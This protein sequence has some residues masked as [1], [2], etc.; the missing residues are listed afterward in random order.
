MGWPTAHYTTAYYTGRQ[1]ETSARIRT[2]LHLFGP[3]TI[4]PYTTGLHLI[5]TV[6]TK[7][8]YKM[9]HQPIGLYK[10]VKVQIKEILKYK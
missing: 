5:E 9:R 3:E 7:T 10:I 6:S 4:L 8:I 2:R 1:R